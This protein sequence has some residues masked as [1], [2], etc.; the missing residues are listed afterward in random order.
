VAAGAARKRQI[1]QMVSF[2][3][4]TEIPVLA[5]ILNRRSYPIPQWLYRVL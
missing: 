2:L 4:Q 3:Q 5:Y 1:R